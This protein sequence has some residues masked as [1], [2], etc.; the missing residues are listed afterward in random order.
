MQRVEGNWYFPPD[1]VKTELFVDSELHT[2]CGW[3]GRAD[4]HSF[5]SGSEMIADVA[6]SYP[7]CKSGAKH[8]EGYWAF[9]GGRGITVKEA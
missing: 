1:A 7:A 6:W 9:Y 3:K 4:Y 2:T 8:I 5:S